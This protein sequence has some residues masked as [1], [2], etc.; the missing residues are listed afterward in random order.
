MNVARPLFASLMVLAAVL[1][2]TPPAVAEDKRVYESL[3]EVKIGRVFYSPQQRELLD[4]RRRRTGMTSSGSK[5]QPG[6]QKRTVSDA[7]GY[8]L[9]GSGK[10]QIYKNGDFV[11]AEGHETM[12]FPGDVKITRRPSRGR[13]A[14]G[15]QST[16]LEPPD[17]ED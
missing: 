10:K 3:P 4:S 6:T 12:H 14:T 1:V 17:V 15:E 13:P 7:A 11:A 2:L 5:A 9:S 16:A 8:I